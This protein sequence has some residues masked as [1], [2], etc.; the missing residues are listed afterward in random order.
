MAFWFFFFFFVWHFQ[1]LRFEIC[2]S[3]RKDMG[4]HYDIH[5][6]NLTFNIKEHWITWHFPVI[7]KWPLWR[8]SFNQPN[9]CPLYF[10]FRHR[11]CNLQHETWHFAEIKQNWN[12][13]KNV[14]N[15][16]KYSTVVLSPPSTTFIIA[17]KIQWH[18][19][20]K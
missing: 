10:H 3:W 6:D 11:F 5:Y 8:C 13:R 15:Y 1:F 9:V 18:D 19:V 4:S 17:G 16:P 12:F 2:F 20:L 7:T 14:I